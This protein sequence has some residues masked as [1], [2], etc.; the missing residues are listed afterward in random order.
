MCVFTV[1]VVPKQIVVSTLDS[2]GAP[3]VSPF[4]KI[5]DLPNFIDICQRGG[6]WGRGGWGRG[7]GA[8]R[9][10]LTKGSTSSNIVIY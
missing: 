7:L 3:H 5:T 1:F 4:L 10:G 6:G 9:E 2:V 8:G